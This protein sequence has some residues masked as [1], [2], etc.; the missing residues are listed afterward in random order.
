MV[1]TLNFM[2]C[3]MK[4]INARPGYTHEIDQLLV[5]NR[6]LQLYESNAKS[7]M[8][9]YPMY[10]KFV[11]QTGVDKGRV[12]R[13]MYIAFWNSCYLNERLQFSL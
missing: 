3:H 9:D 4:S 12:Q 2:K 8:L 6:V 7:V 10:M 1:G 5:Y 13:D 11:N